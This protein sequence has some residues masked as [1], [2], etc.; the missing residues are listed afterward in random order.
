MLQLIFL[1]IIITGV[2]YGDVTLYED[3]FSVL[4]ELG[5][6]ENDVE[7]TFI[8]PHNYLISDEFFVLIDGEEFDYIGQD[9]DDSYKI[10]VDIPA[11]SNDIEIIGS[12]IPI[13]EPE[14]EPTPEPEPE[15]EPTP[16]P[17]EPTPEPEPKPEEPET[18]E[19]PE[20]EQDYTLFLIIGGIVSAIIT[21]LGIWKTR[22]G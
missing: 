15:P 21:T 22:N 14:P 2:P 13:P 11:E 1:A 20:S 16:E 7:G 8:I 12:Q 4:I 10:I 9:Q 6:I 17:E 19:E 3:T 18:P 5:E